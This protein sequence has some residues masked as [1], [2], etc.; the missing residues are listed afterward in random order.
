[1]YNIILCRHSDFKAG[2]YWSISSS[3]KKFGAQKEEF[4]DLF[5]GSTRTLEND[6]HLGMGNIYEGQDPL[7]RLK[8]V[9]GSSN[10]VG[11]N[12]SIDLEWETAEGIR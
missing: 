1:M 11:S 10:G 9:Y 8:N 6:S 12:S 4:D 5:Q 7:K 3:S 2:S